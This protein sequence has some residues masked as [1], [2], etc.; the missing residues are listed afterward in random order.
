MNYDSIA[1]PGLLTQHHSLISLMH[2]A[3]CSYTFAMYKKATLNGTDHE[4][5]AERDVGEDVMSFVLATHDATLLP[6]LRELME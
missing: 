5:L 4:E 6:E 2:L 3:R 1:M